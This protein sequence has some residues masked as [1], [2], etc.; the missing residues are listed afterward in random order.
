MTNKNSSVTSNNKRILKNTSLMYFRTFLVLFVN[1]YTSRLILKTLGV[2][3]LGIYNVV[4]GVVALMSFLQTTQTKATSRFITFELGKGSSDEDLKRVFSLCMT[5]HIILGFTCLILGET[6]GLYI[7]SNWTSIP[8]DRIFAAQ[9]VYQFSIITFFIHIIRVPFDSVI[10]AHERMSIYAYMS[11]VEAGLQLALVIFLLHS[12]LDKLI[13]YSALIMIIAFLLYALY[14]S[15]VKV[16]LSK[17][18][19]SWLWN[20]EESIQILRFSGWTLWG[21][22]AN[23]V[24]QQGISLL[25]NNFV[26]LVANTALGF[27]NQVNAAVNRF[28]NS[29]TVSFNPQIIKYYASG[30][31]LNLFL[32]MNRSAKVSFAL[33]YVMSLPLIINMDYILKIWLDNVPPLTADFCRLILVCSVIDATTGVLNTAITAT[34]KIKKY[35]VLISCSF[36]LDI[37]CTVCLLSLNANVILVFASRI[38]TRGIINMFIGLYVSEKQLAYSTAKYIKEVI[39]PILVVAII[40]ALVSVP[41]V[42]CFSG[43]NL[44]I[45]SMPIGV[46]AIAIL[47]WFFLFSSHERSSFKA[48]I[49]KKL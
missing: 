1:L 20:K 17:Y 31:R 34:G 29:F 25:F 46:F 18:R 3:D 9:L 30:D 10:V 5:I 49:L 23:T 21:S 36:L 32:L 40:P 44:M 45:V 48:I 33:S 12:A 35:Q 24:S 16:K 22:S 19:F 43:I 8:L 38:V 4:G 28:V 47:T 11:I 27:A 39:S 15:Y 6:I 26:G 42:K 2:D 14:A 37:I 13:L 7:V 41:L